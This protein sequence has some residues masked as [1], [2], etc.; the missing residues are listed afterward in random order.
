MTDFQTILDAD[1][2]LLMLLNGSDSLFI[3]RWMA[4]LTCGFTW[5]P[6]YIALLYIVIKNNETMSQISLVIGCALMCV[7][8]SDIAA[9]VIAKPLVGRWRPS[10]DPFIKYAVTVVDGMRGS[11]YGFFSAHAANTFSVAV[12][13]CLLVRSRIL[14]VSLIIWSLINCYTRI[15]LGLH[16]PADVVCGLVCGGLVGC[17]SYYVYYKVFSRIAPA[18]NYIS[19]QYTSTGYSLDDVDIV[20]LVLVA[21]VIATVIAAVIVYI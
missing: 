19:S 18:N 11:D 2:E 4:W 8:V 21:S 6:L 14:S 12:F 1:R 20:E 13:F 7:A 9:D 5:I 17:L 10:N 15:Y 3:D 16:Y